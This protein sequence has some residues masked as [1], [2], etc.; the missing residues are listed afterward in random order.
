MSFSEVKKQ[1]RKL[2]ITIVKTASYHVDLVDALHS[3][4]SLANVDEG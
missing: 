1:L 2:G 3:G 4:L